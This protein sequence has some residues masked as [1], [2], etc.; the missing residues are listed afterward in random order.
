MPRT[1]TRRNGKTNQ[2]AGTR[3]FFDPHQT[4]FF[5]RLRFA[6]VFGRGKEAGSPPTL[7]HVFY[8]TDPSIMRELVRNR[9]HVKTS[10]P[11]YVA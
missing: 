6:G 9:S 7:P 5:V 2:A 10:G 1:L 8:T 11:S 4:K 3:E